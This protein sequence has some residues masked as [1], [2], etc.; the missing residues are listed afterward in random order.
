[1]SRGTQGP[2]ADA[3]R[4]LLEDWAAAVRSCDLG[5]ILA[6]HSSGIVM[7]DVPPPSVVR[8]IEAYARTWR[9]FF[10]AQAA[11]VAFD[12]LDLEI[13][14]GS[15]VAFAVARMR[16]VDR[17]AGELEFRL[18]VGLRKIRGAWTVVHEHHSLPAS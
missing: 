4:R 5:G 13:A 12:I 14:A 1:M 8:G 6:H 11:P 17:D 16:C 10:S 2:E 15:D 18:T 9:L 3:I 7:F